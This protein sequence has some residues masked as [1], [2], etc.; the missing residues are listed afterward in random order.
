M[1]AEVTF[2]GSVGVRIDVQRVVRAG[3]HARLTSNAAVA[4][5]IYD[6]VVASEQGSHGTDRDA[7]RVV[8]VVT[9]ENRKESSSI[10]IFALFNILYPCAKRAERNFIL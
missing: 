10:G 1:G 2:L 7:R 8:A 9:P 6:P 5:K 4:V 3:L